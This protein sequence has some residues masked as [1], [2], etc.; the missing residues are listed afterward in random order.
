TYLHGLFENE[1][2]RNS[3]LSYLYKRKDMIFKS[4]EEGD[5]IEELSRFVENHVDM[6][7]I[8]RKIEGQ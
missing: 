1:N 3:S 7:L 5:S 8:Y 4:K 2:I 6:G